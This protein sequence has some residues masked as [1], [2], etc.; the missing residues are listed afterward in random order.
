MGLSASAPWLAYYG[1]TPAS[2][3]YPHLTMYQM[4]SATAAKYPKQAAYVFMGKET[5]YADFMKRIDAAAKGLTKMGIRKGDKIGTVRVWYDN[6]C[7][8]QQD[9]LSADDVDR[10]K[11]M[12]TATVTTD[13]ESVDLWN[14]IL[15][16][17]L[18]VVAGL[19][20]LV[21]VIRMVN[22]IRYRRRRRRK[23]HNR[24]R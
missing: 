7:L 4:L 15:K 10:A 14:G 12:P 5:T 19:F 21:L 23:A 1:D 16:I 18:G 3:D 8:A 9:L 24:R 17:V 20:V 22:T 13:D 2:R 6:I 11:K